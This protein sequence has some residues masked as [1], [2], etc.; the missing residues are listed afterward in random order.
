MGKTPTTLLEICVAAAG[1]RWRDIGKGTRA[2]TVII[3]WAWASYDDHDGEPISTYEFAE[4][5]GTSDR[6]AWRRKKLFHDVFPARDPNDF[7]GPLIA[8]WRAAGVKKLERALIANVDMS[9]L[10]PA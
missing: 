8:S 4:Y 3:E 1:G 10:V 6:N 9:E 5:W 2:A 7:T